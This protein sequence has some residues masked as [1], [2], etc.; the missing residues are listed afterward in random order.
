MGHGKGGFI[1]VHVGPNNAE[2]EGATAIVKKYRQAC[3]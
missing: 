1:L 3:S 2:K